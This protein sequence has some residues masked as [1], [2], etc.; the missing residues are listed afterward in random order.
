M[1]VRRHA[2]LFICFNNLQLTKQ[3]LASLAE[4]DIGE[5]DLYIVDNGSTDGTNEWLQDYRRFLQETHR[6]TIYSFSENDSPVVVTNGFL[7]EIYQAGYQSVLMVPNDVVL[8]Q[9]AYRL[10]EQW[11]RGIV[12]ASPTSQRDF[13]IFETAKAVSNNT[14]MSLVLLRKWCYDALVAKDGMFFDERFTHYGSDCDF[15]LRLAACGIR[16][17][18]L[19]LQYW[20]YSSATLKLAMPDERRRMERE[21]NVDRQKFFDKWGFKVDDLEY[22]ASAEDI[23]FRGEGR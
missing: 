19:D 14:P 1:T 3:A 17:V 13:P 7:K 9:N 6:V 23:N 2:V 11:P 10:M 21:A 20:H 18:Q 5:L 22:G 15:A 8:P 16:G 4:Q 12:T